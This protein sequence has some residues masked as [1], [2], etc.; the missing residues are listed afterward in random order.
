MLS[1]DDCFQP[2]LQVFRVKVIHTLTADGFFK[3]LINKSVLAEH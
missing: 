1:T 3:K 2:D